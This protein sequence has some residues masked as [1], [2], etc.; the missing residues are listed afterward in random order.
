M[1]KFLR[2]DVLVLPLLFGSLIGCAALSGMQ[3]RSTLCSYDHA[4]AAA[5]DAVKDR[6]SD[7]QD[8]AD[9]LIVT[10]WLEIPMQG[11]AYGI[12]RRDVSDN[13]DRSRLTLKV[14][15]R[16]DVANISFVEER[17]SWVFRGGSR[18]FGWAPTDPSEQV[19]HDLQ[20]RIDAKLQEQGCSVI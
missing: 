19:M 12:F 1:K 6:S 11:R 4:W 9:G 14:K 5:M 16:D 13:K 7:T 2:R 15:Q 3:Q 18:L 8:K 20:R 10:H 17:Q